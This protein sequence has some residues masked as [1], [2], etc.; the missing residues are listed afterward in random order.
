MTVQP[1]RFLSHGATRN[2]RARLGQT[3]ARPDA[4]PTMSAHVETD[5]PE[6]IH[7]FGG[8]APCWPSPASS[9]GGKGERIHKAMTD[10]LHLDAYRFDGVLQ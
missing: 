2:F 5:A 10:P 9:G 8:F 6:T 4:I 1:G 7:D 3:L